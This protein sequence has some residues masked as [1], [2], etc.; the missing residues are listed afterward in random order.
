MSGITLLQGGDNSYHARLD[1]SS[2]EPTLII[3]IVHDNLPP[4]LDQGFVNTQFFPGNR[5]GEMRLSGMQER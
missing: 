3:G 4:I 2:D 5:N 1:S